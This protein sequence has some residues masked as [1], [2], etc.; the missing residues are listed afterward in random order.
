M[1]STLAD[2]LRDIFIVIGV[3][4]ALLALLIVIIG[5]AERTA[6]PLPR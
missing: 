1:L 6:S 5:A 3:M 4:T 2:V